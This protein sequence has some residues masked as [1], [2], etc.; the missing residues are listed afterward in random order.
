MLLTDA[1]PLH[2]AMPVS[3][4]A[5]DRGVLE[6]IFVPWDVTSTIY[7][8]EDEPGPYEEG[9]RRSAF[10]M[11]FEK[12]PKSIHEVTL[13]PRHGSTE[14][15]GQTKVLR[16]T[17]AGLY[18]AVA[19]LP[20]RQADVE[21]MVEQGIDSV[22]IEFLPLQRAPRV[23]GGV[24]WR[25]AAYLKAVAMTAT[26]SYVEARVLA[27]RDE[28]AALEAEAQ[29]IAERQAKLADLDSYLADVKASPYTMETR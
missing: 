1:K 7:G 12:F 24:R 27:V 29:R 19:V 23:A 5:L 4:L 11:Q 16:S 9:F 10:D 15:F 2:R 20:S 6:A 3:E 28:Q 21:Q 13:L 8:D 18:G 26:P 25:T 17:D 22:S 14:T